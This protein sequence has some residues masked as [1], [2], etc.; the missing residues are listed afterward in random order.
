MP[1]MDIDNR[2]NKKE[3]T[4][5]RFYVSARMRNDANDCIVQMSMHFP[6]PLVEV[7]LKHFNEEGAST[8][9]ISDSFYSQIQHV[10]YRWAPDCRVSPVQSR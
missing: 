7:D 2:T 1:F 4:T 10:R 6:N 8:T 5:Q 3:Y 9:L